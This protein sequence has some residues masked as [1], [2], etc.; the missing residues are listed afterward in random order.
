V[1]C[2]ALGEREGSSVG[3]SG[4]DDSRGKS[5][6]LSRTAPRTSNP[7]AGGSNPPRRNWKIRGRSLW[8]LHLRNP[9]HRAKRKIPP[10]RDQLPAQVTSWDL[11]QT[12]VALGKGSVSKRFSRPELSRRPVSTPVRP[13]SVM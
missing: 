12:D 10:R 4:H 13:H 9:A 3:T 6:S 5:H 11:T 1:T 2:K 8:R 7:P